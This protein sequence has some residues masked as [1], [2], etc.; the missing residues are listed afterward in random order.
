[1]NFSNM[2]KYLNIAN[3][4]VQYKYKSSKKCVYIYIYIYYAKVQ[5]IIRFDIIINLLVVTL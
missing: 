2:Q 4:N 5:V 1:M 3:V